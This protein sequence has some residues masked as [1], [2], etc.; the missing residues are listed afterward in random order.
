MTSDQQAYVDK[1][2]LRRLTFDGV[3]DLYH[4][5][6]WGAW[7]V[8][9]MID[10]EQLCRELDAQRPSESEE[11]ARRHRQEQ[12]YEMAIRDERFIDEHGFSMMLD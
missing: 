12:S 3:N 7:T 4:H 6:T 1:N 11:K 5:H 10:R 9:Q 2:R 8:Q